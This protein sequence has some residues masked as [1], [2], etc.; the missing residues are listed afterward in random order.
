MDLGLTDQVADRV[1]EKHD[2]ECRGHT[3]LHLRNQLLG[4]HGLHDH[5]KLCPHL[6]LL[7][8]REAVDDTVNGIGGTHRMQGG[9]DQMSG[10]CCRQCCLDGFLITH[11]TN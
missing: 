5:G 1:V 9:D 8:R 10:L 11:L 7:C 3:A 2:L 6:F 4:N